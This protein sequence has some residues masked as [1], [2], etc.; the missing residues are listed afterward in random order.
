MVTID[1]ALERRKVYREGKYR[2]SSQWPGCQSPTRADPL[3][4]IRQT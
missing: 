3:T 4:S 1:E 2:E